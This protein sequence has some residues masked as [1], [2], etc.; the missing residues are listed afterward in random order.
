MEAA[1]TIVTKSVR[2]TWAVPTGSQELVLLRKLRAYPVNAQD[3]T[4]ILASDAL[5]LPEAYAD[6]EPALMRVNYYTLFIKDAGSVWSRQDARMAV[7]DWYGWADIMYDRLPEIYRNED[8]GIGTAD[9][10]Y[11]WGIDQWGEDPY[12]SP[13]EGMINRPLYRFL[14]LTGHELERLRFM[15]EAMT[16]HK[17]PFEID[18][19]WLEALAWDVGWILNRELPVLRQRLEI[20]NAVYLYKRKGTAAGLESL[21]RALINWEVEIIDPKYNILF[22]NRYVG[23]DARYDSTRLNTVDPLVKQLKDTARDTIDYR[24]GPVHRPDTVRIVLTADYDFEVFHRVAAKLLRILAEWTPVC[25]KMIL[26]LRTRN[27]DNAML[28]ESRP[29]G[30]DLF[31]DNW[32]LRNSQPVIPNPNQNQLLERRVRNSLLW[33]RPKVVMT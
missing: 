27:Y 4:V 16:L 33:R 8:S 20:A 10:L 17:N 14:M 11:G 23:G 29:A 22:R 21:I 12:G 9:L 25:T 7:W 32:L 18:S 15:Y 3:G 26:T 24:L 31:M 5:V 1:Y 28:G 2:L 19:E 6:Q 30:A 13:L